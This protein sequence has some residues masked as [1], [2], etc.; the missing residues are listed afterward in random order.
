MVP[1]ANQ[2]GDVPLFNKLMRRFGGKYYVAA[3][4]NA[5]S[6]A[7]AAAIL[8]YLVDSGANVAV[9]LVIRTD[10]ESPTDEGGWYEVRSVKNRAGYKPIIN[11]FP[12]KDP[13]L[14][15]T[16]IAALRKI[17]SSTERI[18][19]SN[20]EF[21]DELLLHSYYGK[22]SVANNDF[23]QNRLNYFQRDAGIGN[24][25]LLPGA[26]R[27]SF[28]IKHVLSGD[29]DVLSAQI[30]AD[31]AAGSGVNERYTLRWPV[32]VMYV[33]RIR[34]FTESLEH[35]LIFGVEDAAR[36]FG[37]NVTLAEK[38][39]VHSERT[40]IGLSCKNSARMTENIIDESNK[41]SKVGECLSCEMKLF[42]VDKENPIDVLLVHD[43]LTQNQPEMEAQLSA[44]WE[45]LYLPLLAF[46]TVVIEKVSRSRHA[47]LLKVAKAE[48]TKLLSSG[49][50]LPI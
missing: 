7:V 19:N 14:G 8:M 39:M 20:Q 4:L 44:K 38:I 2:F 5:H 22:P 48:C 50:T 1:T 37:T 36:L 34:E 42:H 28:L 10:F 32:R 15:V 11:S 23:L 35:Q 41:C 31:Q 24:F 46:A 29:G 17:R 12:E 45:A 47:Q 21:K 9:A 40:G 16:T 3:M 30:L 43:F 25:R 13:S 18:R 49:W 6:D 27:V 26:I 33:K